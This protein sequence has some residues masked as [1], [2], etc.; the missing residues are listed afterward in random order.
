MFN[1]K[2]LIQITMFLLAI[3]SSTLL[4]LGM[5]SQR[6]IVIAVVGATMG[7]IVTDLFNL[8]RIE[9]A[10]AN[11]ASIVIWCGRSAYSG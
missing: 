6:L 3:V 1:V 2:R 10:L 8:F 7:F 4:G 11:I 9:G 5:E